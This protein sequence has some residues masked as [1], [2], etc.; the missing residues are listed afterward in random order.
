MQH[1]HALVRASRLGEVTAL[2]FEFCA[3]LGQSG[4]LL[5]VGL[6][7][8]FLLGCVQAHALDFTPHGTQPGLLWAME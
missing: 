6:G 2:R 7:L 3:W 5:R 1:R 8:G 4:L